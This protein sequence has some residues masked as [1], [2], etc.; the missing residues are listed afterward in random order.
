MFT[1]LQ[2]DLYSKFPYQSEVYWI[3]FYSGTYTFYF[4]QT[5]VNNGNNNGLMADGRVSVTHGGNLADCSAD[6]NAIEMINAQNTSFTDHTIVGYS[7]LVFTGPKQAKLRVI[8]HATGKLTT[9]AESYLCEKDNIWSCPEGYIMFQEQCYKA[10][11]NPVTFPEAERFCLN[12]EDGKVVELQTPHHQHFVDAWITSESIDIAEFW[13]GQRQKVYGSSDNDYLYLDDNRQPMA[14]LGGTAEQRC[15]AIDTATN[16]FVPKDCKATAPVICQRPQIP[17]QDLL[18]T[19]KPARLFMPLDLISGSGDYL[20]KSRANTYSR[21]AI[22]DTGNPYSG[23]QGSVQ[24]L[25][26]DKSYIRIDNADSDI[27]LDIGITVKMWMKL[28]VMEDGDIQYLLDGADCS[29]G[30]DSSHSF[31]MFLEAGAVD[32]EAGEDTFDMSTVCAGNGP[33]ATRQSSGNVITLNAVLC[34]NLLANGGSCK[35]FK[36]MQNTPIP[37]DQWTYIGFTYDKFNK[38]G[39][40]FIDDVYGYYD[41]PNMNDKIG[42]WFTY[43]T[44]NWLTSGAIGSFITLGTKYTQDSGGLENY[45]GQISCLQ[46]FEERLTPS[47]F[48]HLKKCPVPE[49]YLGKMLLCPN[50]YYYFRGNCFQVP[51]FDKEFGEAEYDCLRQSNENFTISLGFTDDSRMLD[52]MVNYLEKL[53]GKTLEFWYGIDGRSDQDMQS[54]TVSGTWVNS[55]GDTVDEASISWYGGAKDTSDPTFQCGSMFSNSSD[56]RNTDC[57][58][59]KRY[60][61]MTPALDQGNQDILCPTGFVPYK[62][63]CYAKNVVKGVDY[64]GAEEACAYNGSRVVM[65]RDRGTYHFIRA[66]A[67][68]KGS[69]DFYLGLNYT[70]GDPAKPILMADGTVYDKAS[71][72]AFDE[73]SEKFGNKNCTFMKKSVKYVPRDSDCTALMD[74]ICHWNKPTC[75]DGF[76]LYPR[77]IDGRTCYGTTGG[78]TG[79]ADGL[80]T[81]CLA[82]TDWLRRPAIPWNTRLIDSL[83]P[84]NGD[85]MVWIEGYSVG[86][87]VWKNHDFREWDHENKNPMQIKV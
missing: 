30:T 47:L 26:E 64:D 81:N 11:P 72:F 44:K 32:G 79:P 28:E 53:E 48:L 14:P 37:K 46:I 17:T 73:H 5:R 8:D 71:M 39:T 1:G 31:V 4:D 13:V 65:I 60:L 18:D 43:D 68:S 40:F 76:T 50:G 86:D 35:K 38:T 66:M 41:I 77:E 70:T 15:V 54:P 85:G 42:K 57:F 23:L 52:Y 36:S 63:E 29:R 12:E 80:M 27:I 25:G 78:N 45:A 83:K 58:Q 51:R 21:I 74:V 59:K 82:S 22:T 67:K 75:P 3:G 16:G 69:S 24:F 84:S 10:F 56:L 20:K 34:D 33:T 61:C 55:A 9:S 87:N 19:L 7:Q 6:N 49:K 2:D 62:G